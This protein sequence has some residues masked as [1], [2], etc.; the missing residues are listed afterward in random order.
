[1]FKHLLVTLDGSARAEAVVPYA[2]DIG[3]SMGAEV[4]L[5][6]IV[7]ATTSGWGERGAIGKNPESPVKSLN[8]E[9]AQAYLDRVA[10]QMEMS[11]VRT[12]SIVKQGPPAKQIVGTAKKAEADAIVMATHSRRGLNRLMFGSVAEAVLH[13]SDIPILL[14]RVA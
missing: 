12:H 8:V 1:M 13:E 7:D 9:Q 14:V 10:E 6:R 11:G 2:I 3:K 4:T 5:L